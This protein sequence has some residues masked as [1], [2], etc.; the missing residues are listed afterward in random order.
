MD[1][2]LYN[3]EGINITLL[4][5]VKIFRLFKNMSFKITFKLA[6]ILLVWIFGISAHSSHALT[7]TVEKNI[8]Y[9][10]DFFGDISII[11]NLIYQDDAIIFGLQINLKEGWK[12]YWRYA[13]T[14][15]LPTIIRINGNNDL[16][17]YTVLWP[18]PEVEENDYGISLIYKGEI[19][20]PIIIQKT[21]AGYPS[22]V[23]L[24]LELGVCKEICIPVEKQL[25]FEINAQNR[26]FSEGILTSALSQLPKDNLQLGLEPL[27]CSTNI[28]NNQLILDF[29]AKAPFA[30]DSS[31][32]LLEYNGKLLVIKKTKEIKQTQEI[33][34][35]AELEVSKIQGIIVDRSKFVLHLISKDEA[36][37]F[38]GCD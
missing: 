31:W 9:L 38:T 21:K 37:I 30:F 19:I 18:S 36:I 2:F 29:S 17:K 24:N 14:N 15:G 7:P 13:G 27:I 22:K 10:K 28:N 1:D 11:D 35:K 33:T 32:A 34:L 8:S 5:K 23:D 4:Q 16:E 25:T 6:S 12:S 3:I 20:I 26:S